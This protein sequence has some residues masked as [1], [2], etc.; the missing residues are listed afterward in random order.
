V[1]GW[2]YNGYNIAT[3]PSDLTNRGAITAG[4]W[5]YYSL[6]LKK[7]ALCQLGIRV[8]QPAAGLTNIVAIR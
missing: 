5:N 6:A 7:V 2:G 3:P 1:Q 4:D 8:T